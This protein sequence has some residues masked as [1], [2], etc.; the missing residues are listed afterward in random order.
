MDCV[1]DKAVKMFSCHMHQRVQTRDPNNWSTPH[2]QNRTGKFPESTSASTSSRRESSAWP[3]ASPAGSGDTLSSDPAS[4]RPP[5]RRGEARCQREEMARVEGLLRGPGSATDTRIRDGEGDAS[6]AAA[7][8]ASTEERAAS[9]SIK[10][11][12]GKATVK[13]WIERARGAGWCPSMPSFTVG[14]RSN[15]SDFASTMKWPHLHP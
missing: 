6:P 15:G 14:C 7:G 5:P 9:A 8:G 4:R 12:G 2:A 11:R 13:W 10:A 3:L 1:D